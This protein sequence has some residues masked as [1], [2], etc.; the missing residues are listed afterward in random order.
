MNATE[1]KDRVRSALRRRLHVLLEPLMRPH[2][3]KI[4]VEAEALRMDL[5]DAGARVEELTEL[6]ARLEQLLRERAS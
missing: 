2:V 4:A 3:E 6:T 1:A 5:R